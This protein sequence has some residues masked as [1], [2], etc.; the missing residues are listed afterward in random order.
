MDAKSVEFCESDEAINN[1]KKEH[2]PD[3]SYGS[4]LPT[5]DSWVDFRT[6]LCILM[7]KSGTLTQSWLVGK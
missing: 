4:L 7:P 6:V 3:M 1:V 2:W 5:A